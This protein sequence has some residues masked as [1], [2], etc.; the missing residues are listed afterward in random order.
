L[1]L[2]VGLQGARARIFRGDEVRV[3]EL[4]NGALLEGFHHLACEKWLDAGAD[5]RD[6][7]ARE[8]T[9][10]ILDDWGC[11]KLIA[12]EGVE[13]GDKVLLMVERVFEDSDDVTFVDDHVVD[14][15]FEGIKSV[16]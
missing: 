15:K 9:Y 6:D 14:L 2:G 4:E 7:L 12:V 8:V 5:V 13:A 10:L 3:R 1:R 16:N 11:V